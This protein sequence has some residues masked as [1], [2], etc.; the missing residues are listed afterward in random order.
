MN[1]EQKIAFNLAC[2]K[3]E[4]PDAIIYELNKANN[5]VITEIKIKGEECTGFVPREYFKNSNDLNRVI[6]NAKID[7]S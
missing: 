7:I 1:N 6:E 4:F 2:A 5:Y 3:Y